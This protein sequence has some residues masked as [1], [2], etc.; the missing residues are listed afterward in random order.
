MRR[1]PLAFTLI[2]ILVSTALL[3]LLMLILVK[4]VDQTTSTWKFATS[5]VE[6]FSRSRAAFESMTRRISQA[7]LNTYWDYSPRGATRPDRYVRQ[8]ELRFLSAPMASLG[9]AADSFPTHGVF[10][11]APLGFVDESA[12]QGLPNLLNTWGYFVEFKSDRPLRPD[13]INELK[14]PVPERFRFRLMEL[15]QPSNRMGL[16]ARTN[17]TDY[18][19]TDWVKDAMNV[20]PSQ[21][22][23]LAENIVAVVLLPKVSETDDSSLLCPNYRYDST[24]EDRSK[25]ELDKKNQ[26]PPLVQVTLVAIDEPSAIRISNRETMPDLGQ[27]NLFTRAADYQADLDKLTQGLAARRLAYRVFTTHVSIRAAKWSRD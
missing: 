6:Q 8:S 21:A 19:G 7:T 1:N 20:T 10:F 13:F 14:P 27:L 16:Y 15:M 24:Q 9:M 26:L 2:E 18:S 5:K 23:V 11:Q 3:T 12:Y 17:G 25:P 22:H 4:V